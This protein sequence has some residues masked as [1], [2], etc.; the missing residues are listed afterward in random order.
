M[1]MKRI[2]EPRELYHGL[3]RLDMETPEVHLNKE[4]Q[5]QQER[6]DYFMN[7]MIICTI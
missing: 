2:G 7:N 4:R 1:E 3:I 6:I 5:K